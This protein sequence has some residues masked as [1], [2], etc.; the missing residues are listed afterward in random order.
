MGDGNIEIKL[1]TNIIH[2]MEAVHWSS[3]KIDVFVVSKYSTFREEN[4]ETSH[5]CI[6]LEG[7]TGGV[8]SKLVRLAWVDYRLRANWYLKRVR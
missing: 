8:G 3:M 5:H 1:G 2:S 7:A 6:S 4:S